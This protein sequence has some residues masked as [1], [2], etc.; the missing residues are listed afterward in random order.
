MTG[1]YKRPGQRNNM[2]KPFESKQVGSKKTR[3]LN[4]RIPLQLDLDWRKA[5]AKSNRTQTEILIALITSYI[6]FANHD[7]REIDYQI[8]LLMEKRERND[9][10]VIS[11]SLD[12]AIRNLQ[13]Q[14]S[15][16]NNN[17]DY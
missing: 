11:Q 14:A 17:D 5:V 9:R 13:L 12:D 10:N 7:N 4:A 6:K 8:G 3:L 16:Q 15:K 1:E 2:S